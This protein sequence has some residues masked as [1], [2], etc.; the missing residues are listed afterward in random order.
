MADS[1]RM[2]VNFFRICGLTYLDSF[3]LLGVYFPLEYIITWFLTP[4]WSIWTL[5]VC[6]VYSRI[7]SLDFWHQH[8]RFGLSVCAWFT[9]E[10]THS[11][12][13][14]DMVDLDSQDVCDLLSDLLTRFL[15]PTWSIWT[16]SLCV[17][18]SRM[19]SLNFWRWHGWFGLSERAWFTLEST[20]SISDTD[21]V[22]LDS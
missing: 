12:S 22:D 4:T 1:V 9:L 19:Y 10:C 8:G 5:R 18:Y 15:T 11:I 3:Y 13:D 14:T 17:I 21:M 20:H 2:C 16:L 7:Y 6:V